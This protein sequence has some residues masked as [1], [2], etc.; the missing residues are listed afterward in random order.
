MLQDVIHSG[1]GRRARVLGRDDLGG[2]T[3]TTNEQHDTWF[4]GFSPK[5]VAVCWV[6]FDQPRSLGNAETGAK[7][8]LPMWVK[9]MG[10][11]LNGVPKKRFTQPPGMVTV[12]IDPK[13]GLLADPNTQNAIFEIFRAE[14]I[15]TEY[16][17]S[18][19]PKSD[20]TKTSASIIEQ[21]F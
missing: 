19:H 1:T 11:I 20:N 2:K 13:T 7:I 21:L 8:A 9:Y 15:P 10:D 4:A 6:G 14:D 3:G 12:R 5:I 17:N 18:N 16:A